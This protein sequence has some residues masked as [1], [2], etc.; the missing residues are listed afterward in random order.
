[1]STAVPVIYTKSELLNI[2][3]SLAGVHSVN[4]RIV[5]VRDHPTNPAKIIAMWD[6]REGV[7][8]VFQLTLISGDSSVDEQE[9]WSPVPGIPTT[10][11][12]SGVGGT[13]PSRPSLLYVR[14]T[15]PYLSAS[16]DATEEP[17]PRA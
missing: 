9:G 8:G 2:T 10:V 11:G 4:S 3:A 1:M 5:A 14:C 15:G 7:L 6:E 17:Y 13:D 12:Q 16:S